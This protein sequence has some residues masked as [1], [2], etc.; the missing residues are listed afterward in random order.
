M[1]PECECDCDSTTSSGGN[2]K[3]NQKHIYRLI[4]LFIVFTADRHLG[5]L[6][7]HM[8]IQ[9]MLGGQNA[10]QMHCKKCIL[11]NR[12]QLNAHVRR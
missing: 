5:F 1:T 9:L 11:P 10:L 8:R 4:S 3:F 7:P 2:R 12:H 6:G